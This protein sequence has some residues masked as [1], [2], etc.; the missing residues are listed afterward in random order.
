[1]TLGKQ[2][3]VSLFPYPGLVL[4]LFLVSFFDTKTVEEGKIKV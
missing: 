3:G 4:H 2:D 1:M